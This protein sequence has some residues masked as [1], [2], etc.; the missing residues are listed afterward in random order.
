[1]GRKLLS[2]AVTLVRFDW[3]PRDVELEKRN[4]E[5]HRPRHRGYV[6]R[7]LDVSTVVLTSL[8]Q[9]SL[10]SQSGDLPHT[11]PLTW[12]RWGLQAWKAGPMSKACR[13]RPTSRDSKTQALFPSAS[14]SL[15]YRSPTNVRPA[16]FCA[17]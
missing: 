11:R 7:G 13:P 9:K 3:N 1:M 12:H 14:T 4:N 10:H 17:V 5:E 6:Q 8:T 2:Q 15:K 16:T